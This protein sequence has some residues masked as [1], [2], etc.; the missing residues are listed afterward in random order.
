MIDDSLLDKYLSNEL[1]ADERLKVEELLSKDEAIQLR[2]KLLKS[3]KA[4][5]KNE[6]AKQK[7]KSA[8]ESVSEEFK[9]NDLS[10]SVKGRSNLRYLIPI[11]IAATLLLG[12]FIR[13]LI[14]STDTSSLFSEYYQPAQLSLLTKG[15]TN[16]ELKQKAQL[17][18]NQQNYHEAVS[19]LTDLVNDDPSNEQLVF[20][21]AIAE[22]GANQFAAANSR[23]QSLRVHPVYGPGA[24]WYSALATIKMG[25]KENA[26]T[27]LNNIPSQSSYYTS[28]QDLLQKL[29]E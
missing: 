24:H 5:L 20:N 9:Q 26:I 3:Q 18:F 13:P 29:K 1:N 14:T 15:D 21:L 28:A 27:L 16:A 7:A 19:Y 4:F 11:A 6:D 12:L 22:L 8:I 25:N 10:T 17:A 2:L 23:L